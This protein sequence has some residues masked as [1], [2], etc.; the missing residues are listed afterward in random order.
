[1][2]SKFFSLYEVTDKGTSWLGPLIIAAVQEATGALQS[3]R[4]LSLTL[5]I[6]LSLCRDCARS[7]WK[8]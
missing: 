7:R 5:S 3:S 4:P 1:M 6:V 2:E 8:R